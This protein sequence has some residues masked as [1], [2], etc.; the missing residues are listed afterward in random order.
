MDAKDIP[1]TMKMA[2]ELDVMTKDSRKL[3]IRIKTY[4]PGQKT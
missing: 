2:L 1:K 4:K 3:L